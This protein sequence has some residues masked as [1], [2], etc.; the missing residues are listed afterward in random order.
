MNNNFSQIP[1][2]AVNTLKAGKSTLYSLQGTVHL[3]AWEGFQRRGVSYNAK[4]SK[5]SPEDTVKITVG[6]YVSAQSLL[7]L[8]PEQ[9]A[10][11]NFLVKEQS[12]IKQHIFNALLPEY[13]KWRQEYGYEEG[14]ES[15][16]DVAH[17]TEFKNLIGLSYVHILDLS[18]EG[19]AY[20]GYE[21]GCTWDEEHGL[22]VMT[23]KDRVIEI[24]SA[25]TSFESWIAEKDIDPVK[26]AEELEKAK[27]FIF[28]KQKKTWWKFW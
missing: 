4:D 11:Y 6:E 2:L 8:S 19:A 12:S 27:N 17:T 5:E 18:K 14:D 15:M 3:A 25:D 1:S 24:G 16:P 10:A 21:F 23:H 26:A 22:G 13:N 20:V 9:V 7:S 28:P